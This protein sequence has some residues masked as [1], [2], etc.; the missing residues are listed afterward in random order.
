MS[1]CNNA[2]QVAKQVQLT[3]SFLVRVLASATAEDVFAE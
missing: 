3:G 1:D 2:G